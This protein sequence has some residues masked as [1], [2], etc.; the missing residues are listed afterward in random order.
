MGGGM[1]AQLLAAGKDVT[2]FDPHAETL[3]K[4]VARGAKAA[5]TPSQ[6]AQSVDVIILS[7]PK[8]A[9]VDAVMR[10]MLSD[11]RPDTVIL[12][13][14]TSEPTT[15]QAMTALGAEHGFAFVDGPVSGGPAAA[16]AGTMTMLLGGAP[17]AI[18]ILRPVLDVITAKTVTVG[19]SGA[20]HAAKIANNMLCAANLVLVGEALRLGKAAGVAP[21]D[22]LEGIN[23][24]SGRSGVSE[25]NFPKWIL[26][27]AFDS[28]FTMGLMRKDVGL[29]LALAKETKVDISGFQG[30]A[31]IWLNHSDALAD[32]ADFNEIV[33]VAKHD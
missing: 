29:A 3:E 11:I 14:S 5:E 9:V 26:N 22:L 2:C 7:L 15:S 8:A 31:D 33:K 6:L 17:D 28:G 21:Q 20:G 16:N 1:A 32:N 12:D 24:G 25:V 18:E 30:L 13:T 10:D 4:I 23:A 19:G 27:D